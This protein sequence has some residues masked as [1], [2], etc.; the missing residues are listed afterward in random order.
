MEDASEGGRRMAVGGEGARKG[1]EVGRGVCCGDAGGGG[2]SG[3]DEE[4]LLD[5]REEDESEEVEL[6]SSSG[7][8]TRGE[9]LLFAGGRVKYGIWLGMGRLA[10]EKRSS[11]GCW[12]SCA[13]K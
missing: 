11:Q 10:E 7:G 8:H 9:P 1:G 3:S 12:S 5:E 6:L 13:S 2:F 4:V